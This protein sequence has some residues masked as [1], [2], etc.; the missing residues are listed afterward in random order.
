MYFSDNTNLSELE[1]MMQSIPNFRPRRN[2][3]IVLRREMDR[4]IQ[5]QPPPDSYEE[6]L[7][8]TMSAIHYEPFMERLNNYIR[9]GEK[10][11]VDYRSKKHK[12]VFE[13]TIVKMNHKNYAIMSALY[14]L[15]ADYKLWQVMRHH[16]KKNK[17][18]FEDVKLGNIQ[19]EG[20]TLY[21]AAKDLYHGTKH[22]SISDLADK[23]L[24][25][26]KMFAVICNAMAIRRFGIKAI[27]LVEG[28]VE[29]C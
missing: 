26:P 10:K 12:E 2:G 18:D 23:E 29:E 14:L 25:S 15:T 27:Q 20:Y 13:E 17:I 11:R 9:E 19:E 16:T 6:M 4:C 28:K 24:I 8:I 22:I 3:S 7:A 21:C 1:K 5:E